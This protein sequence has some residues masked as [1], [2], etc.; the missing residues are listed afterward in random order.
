M[1]GTPNKRDLANPFAEGDRFHAPE[2]THIRP[3]VKPQLTNAEGALA[4]RQK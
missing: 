2:R 4:E 1:T 3:P